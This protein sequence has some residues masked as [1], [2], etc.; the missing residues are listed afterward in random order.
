MKEYKNPS[1]AVDI[2]IDCITETN[3]GIV[4]IERKNPPL[5]WALPGGFVDEG[6]ALYDTAIREAKEETGLNVELKRQVFAY[7]HPKRDP[8][9]HVVSVVFTATAQGTPVA[10]DDAK[11]A[12]LLGSDVRD[13]TLNKGKFVFDHYRILLDYIDYF[14]RGIS[15]PPCVEEKRYY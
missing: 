3:R 10:A 8:R 2:I 9:Q 11:H 1:L 6:E 14:E 5:G 12:F 15:L 13:W 7:S 4:L